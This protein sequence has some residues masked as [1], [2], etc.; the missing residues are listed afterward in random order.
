M[1][2]MDAQSVSSTLHLVARPRV[3]VF[4]LLDIEWMGWS[5]V[6]DCGEGRRQSGVE[7]GQMMGGQVREVGR[8]EM[9][10]LLP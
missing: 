6:F 8:A 10:F 7:W 5:N 4:F 2:R 1:G 3:P 9:P